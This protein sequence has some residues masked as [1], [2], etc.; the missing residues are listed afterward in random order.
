MKRSL[1]VLALVTLRSV[2]AEPSARPPVTFGM[3]VDA[4]YALDSAGIRERSFTTQP[5]RHNEFAINLAFVE[6]AVATEKLRGRLALQAGTSV[7]ANYSAESRD[8][9]KTGVQLADALMFLQ[10]AFAGYRLAE[11]L[12]VDAGIYFSHIGMESFISKNNWTYTRSLV[13]DFSPYYQAGVRLTYEASPRWALQLHVVNGWQNIIDTNSDKSIGTQ[14]TFRPLERLS[15]T[16]NTLVGKEAD[17]RIFQDLVVTYSATDWWQHGVTVD[18]G[19]QRQPGTRSFSSWY[20]ASYQSRFRLDP[21]THLCARIEAYADKDG[22]IV[23]TGTPGNFEAWGLSLNLDRALI[24]GVLLWRTELRYL[25]A[26]TAI[27]SST[28][29]RASEWWLGVTS[30]SLSL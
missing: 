29:S 28:G 26:K 15:I 14:V 25:K 10:E 21:S 8:P 2:A 19:L 3:F 1:L 5:S 20:G 12:W 27:F 23:P 30:L 22:V 7:L 16:H 11:G 18:L 17:L 6:A 4:Y 13:A 9:S 24:E